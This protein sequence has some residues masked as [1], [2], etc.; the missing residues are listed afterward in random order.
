MEIL[1]FMKKVIAFFVEPLGMILLL[2]FFGLFYLYKNRY[3]KAKIFISLS[4]LFLFLFSYP[5]FSNLLVLNLE[6]EYPKFESS[7]A[8]I[9]Y[10]HVLGSGNSDDL[11]QPLSSLVS[12]AGMKRVI[13]GVMIQK[14][15]PGAKL[16]FT[17]YDGDTTL[18]NATVNSEIALSL[19]VENKMMIVNPLPRDTREEAL[20]A[21]SIVGKQPFVLVTS[22]SHMPR[23]IKLFKDLGMEPVAAPTD[24][25]KEQFTS[26]FRKPN[27]S[28]FLNSQTAV[29]EY[30]GTLWA[31]LLH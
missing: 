10:I 6:K 18:P 15:Y 8:N 1:F 24:F 27:P 7:D 12:D 5:P 30:I 16:I 22:A 11:F 28:A 9:S 19:G 13:E 20:F 29:H 31:S 14:R 17:G 23:A 21:K 3:A 26:W 25:K 2:L 4:F